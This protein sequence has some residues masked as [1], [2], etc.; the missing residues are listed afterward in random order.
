MPLVEVKN[1]SVGFGAF[2]A[3][4]DLSFSI[5]AGERFG[6]IGESG[7]GK[8]LTALAIAGLLPDAARTQG[9]ILFEGQLL[10]E[11]E[12]E[13]AAIRGSKI[14]IVFQEPMTALNPLMRAGDQV[15]EAVRLHVSQGDV[16]TR[17]QALFEEAGLEAHHLSRYPHQLSGGQRQRVMIAMA[18]AGEP[19]LLI[20]DEPTTASP[21]PM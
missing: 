18:L 5:A 12:A 17:V 1:L 6:V 20:C 7:S 16:A 13:M 15:G 9:D 2:T 14:G 3:V 8:T 11:S 21:A 4:D 19:E 10:P